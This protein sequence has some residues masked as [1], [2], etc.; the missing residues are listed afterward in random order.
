MPVVHNVIG[1]R[2][3]TNT[4]QSVIG[5]R[6]SYLQP[7]FNVAG[8]R[9]QSIGLVYNVVG[10]RATNNTVM[11]IRGAR[12]SS[13][14]VLKVCV[15]ARAASDSQVTGGPQIT[16]GGTTRF[17]SYDDFVKGKADVANYT[18]GYSSSYTAIYNG[19]SYPID[20]MIDF[21]VKLKD[22]MPMEWSIHLVDTDGQTYDPRHNSGSWQNILG[23]RPFNSDRI[24][25]NR[26]LVATINYA[27]RTFVY[28]GIPD[29]TEGGGSGDTRVQALT[30]S[31]HDHSMIL[32]RKMQTFPT[33]RTQG[34]AYSASLGTSTPQTFIASDVQ[35]ADLCNA[36]GIEVNLIGLDRFVI[37]V[38][39][40]QNTDY[41]S[42]IKEILDVP[43]CEWNFFGSNVFT[44]YHPNN[45]STYRY[46]FG[47]DGS[48]NVGDVYYSYK[49]E[50]DL[51]VT[52]NKAIFSRLQEAGAVTYLNATDFK[53]YTINFPVP[54]NRL[55]WHV[56]E[57]SV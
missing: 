35:V 25:Y 1:A 53:Q 24:T 33:V 50:K 7:V 54:V 11:S 28:N 8:A 20:T 45:T 21:H 17:P 44:V 12:A 39:H 19:T 32:F 6:T 38:Q 23:N 34:M 14:K 36:V 15:G 55:R 9:A 42:I 4:V 13:P 30:W 29:K 52:Y 5:A 22:S 47:T 31:G 41:M 48:G 57:A 27:G 26:Q 2:A 10:A 3:S 18:D 56:F 40:R 16:V 49:W 46:N 37:P 43:V 51:K